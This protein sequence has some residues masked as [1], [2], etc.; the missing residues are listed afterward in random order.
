MSIFSKSYFRDSS[1]FEVQ[2]LQTFRSSYLD[3]LLYV[4]NG[5]D[6]PPR[7]LTLNV[8]WQEGIFRTQ[9][10]V[11]A[12]PYRW[13]PPFQDLPIGAA[14]IA[15]IR[16]NI[17]RGCTC[18][19]VA[20][21]WTEPQKRVP[22][23]ASTDRC[24]FESDDYE[25]IECLSKYVIVYREK[26]STPRTCR[27][28]AEYGIRFGERGPWKVTLWTEGLRWDDDSGFSAMSSVDQRLVVSRI[29]H[30]LAARGQQAIQPKRFRET[31]WKW[32]GAI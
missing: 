20:L 28:G 4:A 26:S 22:A 29:E 24:T 16:G 8:R 11:V 23:S 13:R 3:T 2:L 14:E 31:W 17:E 27:I 5:R 7:R 19:K 6:Q 1:G 9:L 10:I 30:F 21:T 18:M 15:T 25:I 32:W 12:G